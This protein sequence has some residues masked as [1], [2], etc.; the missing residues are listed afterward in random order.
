[1]R[2]GCPRGR[3]RRSRG[4]AQRGNPDTESRTEYRHEDACCFYWLHASVGPQH[5]ARGHSITWNTGVNLS[6]GPITP[7][8]RQGELPIG[9]DRPRGRHRRVCRVAG[10]SVGSAVNKARVDLAGTNPDNPLSSSMA[11]LRAIGTPF[12]SMI[13][14][15]EGTHGLL[16]RHALCGRSASV[17]LSRRLP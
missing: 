17:D 10:T 1:V 11:S 3:R 13:R 9:D 2:A 14:S 16:R 15:S 8:I 5:R 4:V 12:S 6:L 7:S